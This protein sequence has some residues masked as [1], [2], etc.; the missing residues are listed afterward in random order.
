MGE[1]DWF[2]Y[3]SVRDNTVN[4]YGRGLDEYLRFVRTYRAR[5][6]GAFLTHSQC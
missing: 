6:M 2:R 4:A 1:V 3:P 5:R